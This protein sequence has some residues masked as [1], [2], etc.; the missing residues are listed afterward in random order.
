MVP[1]LLVAAPRKAVV[2]TVKMRRPTF[3]SVDSE[4]SGRVA[5][6]DR[7]N[8]V[9]QWSDDVVQRPGLVETPGLKAFWGWLIC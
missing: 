2:D 1:T 6:D 9:W 7:G 4:P 8:A 5:R 3:K